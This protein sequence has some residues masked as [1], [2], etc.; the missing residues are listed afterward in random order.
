MTAGAAEPSEDN[1]Y[2]CSHVALLVQSYRQLLGREMPL[3]AGDDVVAVARTLFN[4]PYV[5]LSHG[6]EE[7]PIFN[8]ANRTAME[9][10]NMKWFEIAASP[11]RVSAEQPDREQRTR[12]L[13]RVRTQGYIDDYSGVRIAKGGRRF[14]IENATVWNLTDHDGQYVGQA[15][16]FDGW[17]FL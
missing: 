4:A 8:Y 17:Q 10:F 14:S 12:L 15:A 3:S 7:D 5:L 2:Y 11:S 6:T 1:G 16:M 13:D 9:L